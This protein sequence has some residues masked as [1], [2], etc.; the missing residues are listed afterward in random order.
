MRGVDAC[1]DSDP[2]TADECN[3][4]LG[5]YAP[6]TTEALVAPRT[7]LHTQAHTHITTAT[8]S[9]EL[10]RT[11]VLCC[12]CWHRLI[13]ASE[14]IECA[15]VGYCGGPHCV[16]QC[17]TGSGCGPDGCG[18]QCGAGCAAG[19]SCRA[20]HCVS[21]D[22]PYSCL[23]PAP[24]IPTG[25][26]LLGEHRLVLDLAQ[27]GAGDEVS[28]S[29][30]AYANADDLIFHFDVPATFHAG[31]GVD[32]W[33]RGHFNPDVDTIMEIRRSRCS[34]LLPRTA[35]A[36]ADAGAEQG[37]DYVCSDNSE[38]PGGNSA[39][40]IARLPPGPY[41]LLLSTL[42]PYRD[43]P[44]SGSALAHSAFPSGLPVNRSDSVL[45]LQVRFVDGYVQD[46]RL[47]QCGSDGRVDDGCG[48]CLFSFHCN[49]SSFQC[50]PDHCQPSC[51]GR[52][53]GDDGC[54]GDCGRCPT[55]QGCLTDQH[56]C[57]IDNSGVCDGRRPT[58]TPPCAG[59]TFCNSV[60]IA[61]SR[62]HS[63]LDRR[64]QAMPSSCPRRSL[65]TPHHPPLL[66]ASTP[67]SVCV[68]RTVSVVLCCML[69][70]I[71]WSRC[72]ICW[73]S[74]RLRPTTSLR[75]PAVWWRAA[76]QRPDSEKFFASPC[77]C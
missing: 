48:R 40:I 1:D 44:I 22:Y 51:V 31:V 23:H 17:P 69:S 39:R 18:G 7:S 19:Q 65:H 75:A 76:S 63:S 47:K 43:E 64:A 60:S 27:L 52:N 36:A 2:C 35:M 67:T 8:P 29:C 45:S 11:A 25:Q 49:A 32:A 56:L 28:L 70:P 30:A 4:A 14:R 58:C 26:S 21:A 68:R 66:P 15:E 37:D 9:A 73:L 71:W 62:V 50:Q 42:P 10:P 74:C 57:I 72:L 55:G 13:N 6:H 34:D 12:S 20:Y 3:E 77:Q 53:C 24:L 61:T 5:T 59:Q 16:P 33:L 54:G 41:F 46:C 38:P